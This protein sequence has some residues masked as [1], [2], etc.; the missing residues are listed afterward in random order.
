MTKKNRCNPNWPWSCTASF[1]RNTFFQTTITSKIHNKCE[2]SQKDFP[3][4]RRFIISLASTRSLAHRKS[5]FAIRRSKWSDILNGRHFGHQRT[6]WTLIIYITNRFWG[7]RIYRTRSYFAAT[8]LGSKSYWGDC[9]K[10]K[11]DDR[12]TYSINKQ[13]FND[14]H[15]KTNA[16][17]YNRGQEHRD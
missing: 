15:A 1:I 3:N 10:R 9:F 2:F 13:F 16:V 8:M 17:S 4:I 7:Y 14:I 11:A 5:Y 6:Y 12:H